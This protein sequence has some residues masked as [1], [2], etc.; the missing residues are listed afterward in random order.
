ME[1][2]RLKSLTG[3]DSRTSRNLFE[4]KDSVVSKISIP[5]DVIIKGIMAKIAASERMTTHRNTYAFSGYAN[6]PE[7]EETKK[8]A[9]M[10]EEF[11]ESH[12]T[13]SSF[14]IPVIP[15]G[16]GVD[17]KRPEDHCYNTNF[18]TNKIIVIKYK[19]GLVV[20]NDFDEFKIG[21]FTSINCA[22][23][24]LDMEIRTLEEDLETYKKDETQKAY[25]KNL[26]WNRS[27]LFE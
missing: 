20:I 14:H 23:G 27:D 17:F 21:T 26:W 8:K 11:V 2:N 10:L 16:K 6:E 12:N 13:K 22:L 7:S 18:M 1:A 15:R 24:K 4:H 25:I 9:K 3:S 19:D 5:E